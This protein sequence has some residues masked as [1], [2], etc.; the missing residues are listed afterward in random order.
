MR[1]RIRFLMQLAANLQGLDTRRA[2]AQTT[3]RALREISSPRLGGIGIKQGRTVEVVDSFGTPQELLSMLSASPP[4]GSRADKAALAGK[5]MISDDVDHD[6][7]MAPELRDMLSSLGVHCEVVLPLVYHQRLNGVV[8]LGFASRKSLS[9]DDL[10]VL[11][12]AT[13]LMALAMEEHDVRSRLLREVQRRESAEADLRRSEAKYRTLFESAAD[14]IFLMVGDRFVDAN[15][16][17]GEIFG[18]TREHLIGQFPYVLSPE[19]QPDGRPSS[20]KAKE[21]ITGAHDRPQRFEWRHKRLD[22]REFDAE[23]SLNR[24]DLDGQPHLLAMVRDV[25]SRKV[26]QRALRLANHRLGAMNEFQRAILEARSP[27]LLAKEALVRFTELVP[28]DRMAALHRR[29]ERRFEVVAVAGLHVE[30]LGVGVEFPIPEDVVAR[31]EQGESVWIQSVK[32][33]SAGNAFSALAKSGISQ[34]VLVPMVTASGLLG[35]LG[36]GMLEGRTFDASHLELASDAAGQ[37]AIAME[38]ARLHEELKKYATGLEKKVAERTEELA[39]RVEQVERLNA[40]MESL[41]EDLIEANKRLERTSAQLSMANED[42]QAFVYSISHDLRAPLRAM[43]GF[44]DAVL[45]DQGEHIDE[46]GRDYLDRIAKAAHRMDRMLVGLLE[47]ARVS[48]VASS[49]HPVDLGEVLREA[50]ASVNDIVSG[51]KAKIEVLTGLPE[52]LGHRE[53]LVQVL[54]NLLSNAVKYVPRERRPEVKVRAQAEGHNVVLEVEDN[55]RGIPEQEMS[56][57]FGVFERI[58]GGESVEGT[59]IG[60]AIVKRAVERLGGRVSVRS[61]VDRGSTFQITLPARPK[62]NRKREQSPL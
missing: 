14:G 46:T 31:L 9:D 26:A 55:G 19:T 41:L 53:T 15:P 18:T 11:V 44:A 32:K 45:E 62:T 7:R 5:L 51:R 42:L 36:L 24:V 56:R 29:D 50:M 1:S 37:L 52:V 48:R 34:G 20:E 57:I 6:D 13:K 49:R 39:K 28:T 10:D 54:S 3:L 16:R 38:Q 35:A 22:G 21:K 33:I 58:P 59:G 27:R 47:F 4:E 8:V 43:R 17:A 61:Q 30:G 12:A 40:D 2:L 25:T 23:V 60:L